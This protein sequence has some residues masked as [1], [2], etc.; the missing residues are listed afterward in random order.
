MEGGFEQ[1]PP[2]PGQQ[3]LGFAALGSPSSG[4]CTQKPDDAQSSSLLPSAV[5]QQ[6]GSLA[7]QP[8]LPPS[9]PLPKAGFTPNP[10][11][12]PSS[13]SPPRRTPHHLT[14]SR[15][16]ASPIASASQI[17]GLPLHLNPQVC[18]IF[19]QCRAKPSPRQL[20]RKTPM[21]A[22]VCM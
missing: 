20:F 15:S 6:K 14:P 11:P 22:G 21:P 18:S 13:C 10:S 8:P 2:L 4:G 17:I 16:G 1:H 9:R 19:K 7:S 3:V 5:A 12:S